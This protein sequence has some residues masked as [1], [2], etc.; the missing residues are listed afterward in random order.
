MRNSICDDAPLRRARWLFRAAAQ[1]HSGIESGGAAKWTDAT[2]KRTVA[3]AACGFSLAGCAGLGLPSFGGPPTTTIQFE[4]EPAGAEA[5]TSTGQ[6]CR[7]PC[8]QAV[9]GTEFTVTFTLA[10]HQ[11][12][13]VPVRI[14]ASTEPVDP[15]T[16][17]QPAPRMVPNPVFVELQPAAPPAAARR[18][19][20]PPR[21]PRPATAR[22][23]PQQQQQQQPAPTAPAPAP[24]AA[25]PPPPPAR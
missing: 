14:S 7:T 15:N 10:G 3:I 16:G 18:R 1:A 25:W 21:Q 2:M 24:A 8:A 13:T 6:S 20:P 17:V 9:V 22:P 5:R 19:P 4:S 12:Q 11:P 23:A